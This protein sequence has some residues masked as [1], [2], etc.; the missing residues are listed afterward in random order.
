[1]SILGISA[2]AGRQRIRSKMQASLEMLRRLDEDGE[3]EESR[4]EEARTI[5][6][7]G[8]GWELFKKF[9]GHLMCTDNIGAH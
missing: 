5:V 9:N 3:Q 7:G 1:M 8:E 4:K 2:T 6:I